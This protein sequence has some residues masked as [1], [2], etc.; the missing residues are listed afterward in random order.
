M[1]VICGL[2]KKSNTAFQN[3]TYCI[4]MGIFSAVPFCIF[5]ISHSKLVIIIRNTVTCIL[6]QETH[7]AF[8]SH[9][10]YL[11][12]HLLSMV[13]SFVSLQGSFSRQEVT[14]CFAWFPPTF[15]V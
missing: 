10:P 14:F 13:W 11:P 12:P 9:H 15:C 3:V 5:Q 7:P 6:K 1:C 4:I 8:L 2:R